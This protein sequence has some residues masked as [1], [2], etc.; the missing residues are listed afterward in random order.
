M[1]KSKGFKEVI[2]SLLTFVDNLGR[3]TL[4]FYL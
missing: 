2:N 1:T 3:N 4:F